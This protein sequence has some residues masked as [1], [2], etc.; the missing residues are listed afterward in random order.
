MDIDV[1]ECVANIIYVSSFHIFEAQN[2]RQDDYRNEKSANYFLCECTAGGFICAL[3]V[4][5]CFYYVLLCG[6]QIV[7]DPVDDSALRHHQLAQLL[8]Q[9][10][11][12]ADGSHQLTDLSLL[13]ADLH[14][15][16]QLP[17]VL[18]GLHG[19]ALLG[20]QLDGTIDGAA[21]VGLDPPEILL[22]LPAQTAACFL[23]FCGQRGLHALQHCV[24][25]QL[26][27]CS[28]WDF[29][30]MLAIFLRKPSAAKRD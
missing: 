9:S 23:D 14:L 25:I 1:C 3:K 28:M 17:P 30:S 11:Q 29:G 18:G 2:Y 12:P 7:I 6:L 4:A 15:L 20:G 26:L 10:R 21:F 8:I 13:L 24:T 16:L 22:L 5:N 27:F 19:L